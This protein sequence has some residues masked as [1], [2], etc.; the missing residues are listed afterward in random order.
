M[1]ED[2]KDKEELNEKE[3]LLIEKIANKV[4]DFGF[5][6]PAVLF[7]ET[8][9]PMYYLWGQMGRMFLWPFLYLFGVDRGGETLFSVLEDRSKMEKLIKKIEKKHDESKREKEKDISDKEENSKD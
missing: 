3:E 8:F 9:K 1:I 7:L 2:D 4:L 5:E 6:V